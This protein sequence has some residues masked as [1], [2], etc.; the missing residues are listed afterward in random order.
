MEKMAP[1]MRSMARTAASVTSTEH[2]TVIETSV[3]VVTQMVEFSTDVMPDAQRLS[4]LT[5]YRCDACSPVMLTMESLSPAFTLSMSTG[6]TTCTT[7]I[8]INC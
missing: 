5:T 1:V 6:P 2:K 3:S 7:L 8:R 4:A